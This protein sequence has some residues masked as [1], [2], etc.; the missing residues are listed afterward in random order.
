[1]SG[2]QNTQK[3]CSNGVQ[4]AIDPI[5]GQLLNRLSAQA[6]E[7]GRLKREVE[8]AEERA[9]AAMKRAKTS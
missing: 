8:E 2:V 9:T 5:V 3:S 7:I 1:L 6:E 4:S